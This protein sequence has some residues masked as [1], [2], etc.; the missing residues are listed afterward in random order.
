MKRTDP[1]VDGI[2]PERDRFIFAV[3]SEV[4]V[5]R[6][7]NHRSDAHAAAQGLVAQLAV[8]L[9]GKA[10]VGDDI[11]GHGGITISRYRDIVNVASGDLTPSLL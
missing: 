1:L 2:F 10:Q 4:A 9:L 11:A 8:G 7:P 3:S 5:H 6:F